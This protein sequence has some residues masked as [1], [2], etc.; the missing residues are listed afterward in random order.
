[1]IKARHEWRL[2]NPAARKESPHN[3]KRDFLVVPNQLIRKKQII[4]GIAAQ[5]ISRYRVCATWEEQLSFLTWE[6]DP[7]PARFSEVTRCTS[8]G[9]TCSPYEM[10]VAWRQACSLSSL[11]CLLP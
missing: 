3:W 1:M 6:P 7:N 4:I 8:L 11:P 2:H 9:E 10:R 5:Q